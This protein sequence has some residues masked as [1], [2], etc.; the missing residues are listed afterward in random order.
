[1]LWDVSFT[2]YCRDIRMFTVYGCTWH[3]RR[4]TTPKPVPTNLENYWSCPS[5]PLQ[6]VGVPGAA[7]FL[8]LKVRDLRLKTSETTATPRRYQLTAVLKTSARDLSPA[9]R[10]LAICTPQLF[11][12]FLLQVSRR[13]LEKEPRAVSYKDYPNLQTRHCIT[14]YS[15]WHKGLFR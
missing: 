15:S 1:M 7:G 5:F 3:S 8:T 2:V 11:N 9:S 6:F 12:S 13:Q 4:G 14:S 10:I